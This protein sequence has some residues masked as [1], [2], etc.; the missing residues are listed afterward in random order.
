[1]SLPYLISPHGGLQH[2]GKSGAK[3]LFDLAWG[4]SILKDAARLLV[5]SEKEKTD[6][7]SFGVGESRI[8]KLANI[9]D[10]SGYTSLPDRRSSRKTILFLGRL[11]RIK[12]IDLL[13]EAF[14]GL[15]DVQLVLAGPDDGEGRKIPKTPDIIQTGFLAHPSKL[16]AIADSDV[17]VLPSRS[18]AS[19]VVMYEALLCKRPVVVSSACELPMPDPLEYGILKFHSLD[20]A[21]LQKQLLFALSDRQLSDNAGIGRDYVL[22]EFSPNVVAGHAE[23]IYEEAV[24]RGSKLPQT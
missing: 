1:M 11:N 24:F 4:N 2:L 10:A 9:I 19:P 8:R 20:V 12:G 22:R 15:S 7:L 6:A 14:N 23:K 13:I 18:E 16:Q 21:D 17:V 3:R 5:L